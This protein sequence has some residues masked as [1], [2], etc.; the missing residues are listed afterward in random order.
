M[1]LHALKGLRDYSHALSDAARLRIVEKLAESDRTVMELA[2]GLKMSQPLVSWHLRRLVRAGIVKMA[3]TGR[4]VR[5]SLNRARLREYAR[6]F[7]SLFA[8]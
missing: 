5:V 4:Q 1:E 8:K 6:A 3:R 7:E 2:R